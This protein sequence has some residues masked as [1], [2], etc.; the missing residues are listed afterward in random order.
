[1][2]DLL[3]HPAVQGGLAPL[4]VALLV[5]FALA[6]TRFAWVAIAAGYATM[7]ALTVGFSFVPLTIARKTVVLGLLAPLLGIAA[8]LLPRP[9]R[10]IASTLARLCLA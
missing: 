5:G 9:A 1:M 7:V 10:A 8:D 6:R 2:S 3:Q 4:L